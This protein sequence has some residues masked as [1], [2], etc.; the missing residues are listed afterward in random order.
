MAEIDSECSIQIL[1]MILTNILQPDSNIINKLEP[2][3][4]FI[5]SYVRIFPRFL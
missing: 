5:F 4:F 1:I 3:M 2:S